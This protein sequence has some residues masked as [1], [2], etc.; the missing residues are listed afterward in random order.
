[1][2]CESCCGDGAVSV[3]KRALP[4]L[5]RYLKAQFLWAEALLV[6]LIWQHMFE[7]EGEGQRRRDASLFH[8][9]PWLAALR[10]RGRAE[11][12]RVGL[13]EGGRRRSGGWERQGWDDHLVELLHVH[14][15]AHT[16]LKHSLPRT[17][18]DISLTF[19][20]LS[21]DMGCYCAD[22]SDREGWLLLSWN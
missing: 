14:A 4:S 8:T 21:F 7:V 5:M 19:Y 12:K 17:Q 11:V 3:V 13:G 2:S 9:L 15:H 1:M 6:V 10:L 22:S 18:A 20:S 16:P